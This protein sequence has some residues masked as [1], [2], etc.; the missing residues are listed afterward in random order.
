MAINIGPARIEIV[1]EAIIVPLTNLE[2]AMG[3]LPGKFD[4]SVFYAD[5]TVCDAGITRK[6]SY[7]NVARPLEG[8]NILP[9]ISGSHVFGGML[10]NTHFGHFVA[11]SL[12][13]LWSFDQLSEEYKSVLFFAR[14]RGKP[15]P[16]W[17]TELFS[18]IIPKCSVRL[19]GEPTVIE[20]LA[21]PSQSADRIGTIHGNS[22]VRDAMSALREI[23]QPAG[24]KI[25]V[26]RSQLSGVEGCILVEEYLEKLLS[27]QGYEIIHP[28]RMTIY[29][30]FEAYNAADHIIFSEGSAIHL[31]AL[32]A[33]SDQKTFIVWRRKSGPTF[34]NQ[35]RSF[36]GQ[37]PLGTP[38]IRNLYEPVSDYGA[39]ARARA[40]IDFEVLSAQLVSA[41]FIN[42]GVQWRN[43][44]AAD[45]NAA[46][47]RASAIL[48]KPMVKVPFP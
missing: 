10:Q 18:Y 19:I 31:Y 30:Q 42:S 45:V 41:G 13:R 25:F 39:R 16:Q 15:I 7:Q 14:V 40:E 1:D 37:S 22:L 46:L 24:K 34:I 29:Q 48:K 35:V 26:S 3:G 8:S 36:G 23:G 11:E 27:D 6:G 12:A 5:G 2:L 17:A 33:R 21:V 43:P 32:A 44:P 28:E 47:E 20:R 4:G 38:A 9:R